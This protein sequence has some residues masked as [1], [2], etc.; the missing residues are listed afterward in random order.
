MHHRR[1]MSGTRIVQLVGGGLATLARRPA[2]TLCASVTIDCLDGALP[3]R[4]VRSRKSRAAPESRCRL[5][6]VASRLPP[7]IAP[8]VHVEFSTGSA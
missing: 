5:P 1:T 4:D 7:K 6:N 8:P 2:L 3:R